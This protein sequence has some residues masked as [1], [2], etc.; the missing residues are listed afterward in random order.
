MERVKHKYFAL[1]C[2]ALLLSICSQ[3]QDDIPK[4]G[5]TSDFSENYN[6]SK[7]FDKESNTYY[8]LTRIKHKD[9]QGKL[10]KLRLALS[11]KPEGEAV[12][13]F[14]VRMNTALAFNASMGRTD[15]P[16]NVRQP[17]GLQIIDG[18][19]KQELKAGY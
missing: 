2:A 7:H 5:R 8:Y 18:V 6:V 1:I 19:I 11:N 9:K 17:K 3:A 16:P 12:R 10:I 14:A 4:T 13:A 15:L